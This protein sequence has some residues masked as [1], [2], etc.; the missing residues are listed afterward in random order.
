[1]ESVL[2]FTGF[3]IIV[4][5][6]RKRWNGFNTVKIT[7]G[8]WALAMAIIAGL[9]AGAILVKIVEPR[10]QMPFSDVESLAGCVNVGRCYILME[11]K[12]SNYHRLTKA[13]NLTEEEK[14]LH[15]AV[16]R[17]PIRFSKSISSEIF[18]QQIKFPVFFSS[19]TI[20]NFI[21]I[22][23]KNHSKQDY[24]DIDAG[25]PDPW[26]FPTQKGSN[27]TSLLTSAVLIAMEKGLITAGYSKYFSDVHGLVECNSNRK[28]HPLTLPMLGGNLSI[29]VAGVLVAAVAFGAEKVLYGLRKQNQDVLDVNKLSTFGSGGRVSLMTQCRQRLESLLNFA[30]MSSYEDEASSTPILEDLLVELDSLCC[31]LDLEGTVC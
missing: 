4:P 28:P 3:A 22:N 12:T 16:K 5:A 10:T 26:C 24:Y 6:H 31:S 9:Y 13:V 11:G 21:Q 29:L 1:M 20:S 7:T 23:D 8:L 18:G 17:H 15:N 30:V 14:H 25:F 2:L 27:L 19:R